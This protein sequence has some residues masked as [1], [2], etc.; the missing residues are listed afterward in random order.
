MPSFID[1]LPPLPD[2]YH[3]RK[4]CSDDYGRG[5]LEVL[6]ALTTV[7]EITNKEFEHTIETWARHPE[8]YH[9]LVILDL[10]ETVVAIGSVI[11]ESKLIHHCGKVGHIEDIAVRPNQ[12]GK[13]LGCTL[14]RHLIKIAG[15]LDCYKVI[16]D[17]DPAN[18]MFYAKCGLSKAGTEMQFRF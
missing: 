15:S 8:I 2:G 13:K 16:L 6:K 17:C 11:V 10:S 4:I 5:A 1:E 18:E 12:Q 9:T 14:I 7:G 3:I